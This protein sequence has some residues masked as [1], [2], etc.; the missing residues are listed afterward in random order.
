MPKLAT[1][2]NKN[3]KLH[4]VYVESEWAELK[5]CVYGSPDTWVL[6]VVHNDVKLRAQGEFGKFWMKNQGKNVKQI[7]P[8]LFA[9]FS[10]QI[11]GAIDL[12]QDFGVRVQVAGPISPANRKYL[13]RILRRALSAALQLSAILHRRGQ[14][15]ARRIPPG[16]RSRRFGGTSD[17]SPTATRRRIPLHHSHS[18]GY[19]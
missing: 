6:P 15:P 13:E 10:G 11:Q 19:F 2:T 3:A 12:L 14:I 7:A 17:S 5:E 8:D 1:E 9:E 16:N 4:F 18:L